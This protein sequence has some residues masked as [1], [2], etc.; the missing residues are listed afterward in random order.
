MSLSIDLKNAVNKTSDN[1]TCILIQLMFKSDTIN[2]EKLASVYPL[3]A[4]M[5]WL[6]K[7]HCPYINQE[8][9]EVDFNEIEKRAAELHK[10]KR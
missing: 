4:N 2:F 8:R 10:I 1:F 5:V 6:Y 7:N 9:T 3:E